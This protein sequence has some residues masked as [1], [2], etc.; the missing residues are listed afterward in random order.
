MGDEALRDQFSNEEWAELEKSGEL[1]LAEPT[2][3]PENPEP[4]EAETEQAAEEPE[5]APEEEAPK[6][7]IEEPDNVQKRID[8]LT[9]EKNEYQRKFDLFRQDPDA[10]Y[11]Q[12]PDERPEDYKPPAPQT[13][14]GEPAP[15]DPK[16]EPMAF[17]QFAKSRQ[18]LEGDL[19]GYTLEQAW[20][21]ALSDPQT[22][23]GLTLQI[24]DAYQKYTTDFRAQQSEVRAKA[25]KEEEAF[26]AEYD[27]FAAQEVAKMFPGKAKPDDLTDPAEQEK[28]A[29]HMRA[30]G[31]YMVERG[32]RHYEDAVRLRDYDKAIKEAEERGIKGLVQ[33][34]NKQGP[35]SPSSSAVGGGK[36]TDPYSQY[37]NMSED[38]L[39]EKIERMS[40]AEMV[41][42]LA[43]ATP[44]FKAK[45]PDLP[46]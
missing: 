11:E 35:R 30:I 17:S 21:L 4:E 29:A 10:Y 3:E 39:L 41:S 28:F 9:W 6:E 2:E 38:A 1:E 36:S 22:Y 8:R 18:I 42:F 13:P 12:Y 46:Y 45:F 44:E 5:P 23:G 32:I 16:A 25:S 31:D 34:T 24:Q 33:H 14:P 19:A 27:A 7:E 26:Y 40:D 20:G 43:K 37:A 15:T